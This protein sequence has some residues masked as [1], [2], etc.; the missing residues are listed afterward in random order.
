M[1]NR[2]ILG[3]V[4]GLS[5]LLGALTLLFPAPS[6]EGVLGL[7]LTYA[8]GVLIVV[9]GGIAAWGI[10]GPN[11]RT[12]MYGL[13]VLASGYIVYDIGLWALFA[14]RIGVHDGLPPPYGPALAIAVLSL[15][16]VAKVGFLYRK[17]SQLLK[18][19]NNGLG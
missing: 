5:I 11:Y 14:E 15:F 17:N 1:L 7:T 10:I 8:Y 13:W 3:G 12:E 4:Y 2:G 9:G 6:I 16:L 18:A 19:T